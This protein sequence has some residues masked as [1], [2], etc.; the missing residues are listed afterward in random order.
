MGEIFFLTGKLKC[1]IL[2]L[3]TTVLSTTLS[4]VIY[5][6]PGGSD[7]KESTSNA[8]DMG[9]IPGLGRS[10]GRKTWQL[11]PVFLPGKS[12]GQ[13]NLVSCSPW[14]R[15]RVKHDLVTKQQQMSQVGRDLFRKNWS[16]GLGSTVSSFLHYRKSGIKC[17]W[18]QEWD[19]NTHLVQ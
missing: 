16:H 17:W 11:T 6:F 13:R 1:R 2:C 4:K 15:K 7:G 5:G 9:S 12:R 18:S 8:G 14:G 3:C 10:P 19:K